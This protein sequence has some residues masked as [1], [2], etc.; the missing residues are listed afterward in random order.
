MRFGVSAARSLAA[1]LSALAAGRDARTN[2]RISSRITGVVSRRNGC[3]SLERRAERAGARAAAP[4]SV[5][6]STSAS[7][8]VSAS[9]DCVAV[10][11]DGSSCSVARRLASWRASEAK[12]AFELL[13]EV[14]ELV[15]AAAELLDDEREVVDDAA[16]VRAALASFPAICARVAR[17]RLEAADRVGERAAVAAERLAALGQQQLQVGPRVVVERR[18]DL[19]EVDVRRGLPDR[20]PLA[21]RELAGGARARA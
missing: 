8:L 2:G 3:V 12:T 21:G 11:V 17:G 13:D 16:D 5:G 18:E 7:T 20:D 6:P 4:A 19:V 14:G 10:S 9:A 1:G 15:V